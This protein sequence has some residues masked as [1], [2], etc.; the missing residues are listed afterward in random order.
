MPDI[1]SAYTDSLNF[2]GN[3][4][5]RELAETYGTPL[6]VYNENILRRRCRDLMALSSQPGFGVNYSVKANASPVLLKIIREE[7]LVVDAMSP[8]ELFMDSLAGFTPH[9]ILYIS[10]NNS[11]TEL[12]NALEHGLLISVDSLSQLDTLGRLNHGGKVMVRFNPGIGAGHHAKVVTAGKETKFGVTPDKMSDVFS[13]LSRHE[14]TLAGINQ[15]IGSLFMEPDGYLDAAQILLEL[16][17]TLPAGALDTLEIIDFGG[18]FGIP[19]RKYEGEARLNMDDLGRRLHAMISAWAAKNAYKGRFL[20]EPGRYV[21]AECGVL[22]GRVHAVKNNGDKR[23]VGTNLGFNV[24][25]RPAMYDSFHDVEIYRG[26]SG[27]GEEAPMLQ[28]IVGNICESGDILAKNRLLPRMREGDVLGILDA[29]A[30]G[31]TMSSNYNQRRRPA[32]VLIQ[33]D[34]TARL[35]RRRET[36]EDM[37]RCFDDLL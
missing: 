17:E 5:P 34:G 2:Y 6:Y 26:Q 35:I 18:G 31:F 11:E 13:L 30:Y 22:L 28:T 9:E 14:L 36:L 16:A 29:G 27:A 33:S 23:Y 20:V 25:V 10:N 12:Q 21:A 1:R 32:E 19:Y 37:A 7:G 4:S 3:H 8:G 15:H 24:L